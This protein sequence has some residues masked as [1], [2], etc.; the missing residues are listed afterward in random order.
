MHDGYLFTL[1]ICGSANDSGPARRCL[2]AMLAALP[3]VKRAAYLG[4]V[5][6]SADAP[7]FDDPLLAPLLTDIADAEVLLVV[8]PLPGGNLPP[9]LRGL[10]EALAATPPPA[11]RRFVALVAVGDGSTDGLWPV[12][13]ALEA[14]DAENIGELYAGAGTDVEDLLAEAVQLARSAFSRAHFAHPHALT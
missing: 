9:R 1:G 12:R 3:P 7:S 5:L 2:D 11:R 8:T 14:L 10:F 4:E 13:Q 6:I